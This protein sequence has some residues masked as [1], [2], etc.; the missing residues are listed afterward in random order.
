MRCFNSGFSWVFME[1]SIF[2]N[3]TLLRLTGSFNLFLLFLLQSLVL[4]E[5]DFAPPT[6][7]CFYLLT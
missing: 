4:I 6:L 1:E 2:I 5:Y 7:I 3:F